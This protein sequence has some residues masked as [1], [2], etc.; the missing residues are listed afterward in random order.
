VPGSWNG[1]QIGENIVSRIPIAEF[2]KELKE[3]SEKYWEDY[4]IVSANFNMRFFKDKDS[5]LAA[6]A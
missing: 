2:L 1:I 5:A 6:S 3:L 4:Q